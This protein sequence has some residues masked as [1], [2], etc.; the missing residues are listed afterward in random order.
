MKIYALNV[1]LL[2]RNSFIA[3]ILIWRKI[4]SPL[5]G[6]VCRFYPSCS[7]YGLGSIQQQGFVKGSVLTFWRILRCNPFAKGG[8]DEVRP[9]PKWLSLT[10]QGFVFAQSLTVAL[11]KD[12]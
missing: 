2:P 1:W 6:D 3:F 9:G 11:E 4:I 8:V 10:N 5:Y 7:A 12:K